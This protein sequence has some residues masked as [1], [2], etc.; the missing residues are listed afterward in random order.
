MFE[1]AGDRRKDSFDVNND[2]KKPKRLIVYLKLHYLCSWS[3]WSN[4]ASNF[5]M[6]FVDKFELLVSYQSYEAQF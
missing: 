5:E 1:L 6:K 4:V 2:V 3:N